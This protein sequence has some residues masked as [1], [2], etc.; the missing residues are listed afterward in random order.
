MVKTV[1]NEEFRRHFSELA[2]EVRQTGKP[3]DIHEVGGKPRYQLASSK[4]VDPGRL[5][6]CVRVG[7]HWLR[8]NLTEVRGF[9]LFRDIPFALTV[10]G[11]VAVIFQRHP[12]YRSA[13][14]DKVLA[15]IASRESNAAPDL[16]S[17]VSALEA[18]VE[19]M[20]ARS[21]RLDERP[22]SGAPRPKRPTPY[23]KSPA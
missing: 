6:I 8:Q 21:A 3:I 18:R 14:E 7:P 2:S 5:R 20:E 11:E 1:S 15:E 16:A 22:A 4:T 9:A 13:V 19:A 23:K 10:G 12:S 17:R